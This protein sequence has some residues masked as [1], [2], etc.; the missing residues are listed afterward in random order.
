ME[1]RERRNLLVVI[2]LV[3]VGLFMMVFFSSV[4]AENL[5]EWLAQWDFYIDYH[6]IPPVPKL[7]VNYSEGKPGSYFTFTGQ[8][9]PLTYKGMVTVN[10][11]QVGVV[12]VDG[13]GRF[14]FELRTT[15]SESLQAALPESTE[16][17]LYIVQ[18]QSDKAVASARFVL[19]D[20]AP[21]RPSSGSGVTFSVP[22]GIAYKYFVH[23]PLV[24]R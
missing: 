20:D 24:T 1:K 16:E 13:F 21:F 10:T 6:H 3:T 2:G 15:A 23:L 5:S 12:Q 11:H 8:N 18:V 9:F 19:S 7:T 14:T 22:A 4:K 17:G